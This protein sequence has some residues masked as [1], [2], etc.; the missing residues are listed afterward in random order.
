[1]RSTLCKADDQE[2]ADV[3]A[4]AGDHVDD[5]NEQQFQEWKALAKQSAWKDFAAQV[6]DGQKLLDMATAVA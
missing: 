5:M 1:M 4:K 2:V 6:K 3:F